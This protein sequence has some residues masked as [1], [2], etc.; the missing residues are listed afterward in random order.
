MHD[1]SRPPSTPRDGSCVWRPALHALSS[2]SE[3]ARL[4][5]LLASDPA[6]EIVDLVWPQLLDLARVREPGRAPAGDELAVVRSLV[7]DADLGRYGVAVHY[8]WARRVVRIVEEEHFIEIRTNRNRDKIRTSE[9]QA[10]R[11]KKV[12][13]VGVSVGKA[14]A[15]T[16]ALERSAGEIRLADFDRIDLS[17]LNRLRCSLYDLGLPKVVVT[18]REIAELDPFLSVRCFPGGLQPDTIDDFFTGGGVL[19]AVIEECDA[20]DVKLQVREIASKLHIPVVMDTSDRGM[21]DVE[22]FDL[23]PDRP[24]FHGRLQGVTS[25][26]LRE[27][28]PAERVDYVLRIVGADTMSARLRSSMP[29]IGRSLVTWPQLA[30]AV[31][32]G[33]AAAAEVV[34]RIFLGQPAPSGRYFVD[35]QELTGGPSSLADAG[36]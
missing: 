31:A 4:A 11:D 16:I 23:E 22:R 21:L 33:G 24:P 25:A 32:H 1:W 9:Q 5:G 3:R 26:M 35:L 36:S 30:T 27:L 34:R 29:E 2:E 6:I 20:I 18:A 10:L 8:P 28:S 12:G 17:N 7:P 13:I 15:L 14:V 19:D